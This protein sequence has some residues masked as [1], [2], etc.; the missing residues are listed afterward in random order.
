MK[1][2][3]DRL[4]DHV[5]MEFSQ[6]G[7]NK[8]WEATLDGRKFKVHWGKIGTKGQSQTRTFRTEE[9]ALRKFETMA[10]SKVR[11]GYVEIVE[12]SDADEDEEE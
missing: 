2:K 10:R 9:E 3:E 12:E 6:A 1:D 7:T 8:F 11:K 5:Y 4:K